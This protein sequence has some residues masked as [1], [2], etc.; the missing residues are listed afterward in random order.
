[1]ERC[2]KPDGDFFKT[3]CFTYVGAVLDVQDTFALS[4]ATGPKKTCIPPAVLARQASAVFV[5]WAANNPARHHLPAAVGIVES[6][7]SA[8]PCGAP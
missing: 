4:G 6:M 2:Q 5:Q 3:Y 7:A 8:F 1:M